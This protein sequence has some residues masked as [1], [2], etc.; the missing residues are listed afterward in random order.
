MALVLFAVIS[1]FLVIFIKNASW[2]WY[3]A[4]LA[5]SL[6][7]TLTRIEGVFML[8]MGIIVI[9]LFPQS[10]KFLCGNALKKI[11]VPLIA[12]FFIFLFNISTNLYFY[13]E[14]IKAF[15]H[16][17]SANIAGSG[18]LILE[19]S[20]NIKIFYLY[21]FLPICVLG[22]ISI[23][24][25]ISRKKWEHLVP[26][27]IALPAFL[28]L[29]IP[30]ISSDHPWMLRRFAF[31]FFP[32]LILTSFWMLYSWHK[33]SNNLKKNLV[34]VLVIIILF[35]SNFPAL[36]KFFTIHENRGLLSRTEVLS[37]N[38][39]SNDL[40]LVDRDISGDGWSMIT[41]PLSFLYGINAVYFFN[42]DDYQKIDKN[43]F[44]NVYLIVPEENIN[45]YKESSVQ[46]K[47][48]IASFYSLS[49]ERLNVNSST[50]HQDYALPQKE[51][52]SASG[53][54]YQLSKD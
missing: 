34:T 12:I 32:A 40:V 53:Y 14:I 27:I 31:S 36:Q 15:T 21:G 3:I 18:S 30:F 50:E 49:T 42:P 7:L 11:V 24:Y 47:M 52:V 13:K 46:E 20:S 29:F 23:I 17:V 1:Y 22:S 19:F 26:L 35:L 38:F 37:K 25:F 33:E 10:R 39:T 45:F 48:S 16:S 28:Y 4:F 43:K 2:Q 41:G 6:L 8:V 54:I 9:L 51:R 5:S 44:E